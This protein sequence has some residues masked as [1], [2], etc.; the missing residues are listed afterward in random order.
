MSGRADWAEA[1]RRQLIVALH[2]VRAHIERL[3]AEQADRPES[4]PVRAAPSGRRDDRSAGPQ[5]SALDALVH[6]FGLT[7][8]E[9]DVLVLAAGTELDAGFA[10]LLAKATGQTPGQ[11]T[12]S[13]ALAALPDAHWSAITPA[14]PLRRWRLIDVAPGHA[15]VA[16]PLRIDER[17]LHFLVGTPHP[18]ERLR[19]IVAHSAPAAPAPIARPA[20]VE[21]LVAAW[22]GRSAGRSP[23]IALHGGDAELRRAMAA[24]VAAGLGLGMLTVRIDRVP[25]APDERVDLL[26]L[27]ERECAL[28]DAV[29]LLDEAETPERGHDRG[30]LDALDVLDVPVI[31]SATHPPAGTDRAIINAEVEPLSHIELRGLWQA[32][33]GEGVT[34][35]NGALDRVAGCFRLGPAGVSAVGAAL[36]ATPDAPVTE[37]RL[38]GLC[39]TWARPRLDGLA[40]RISPAATWR[41][42]VLPPAQLDMLRSIALHV[43]HRLTVHEDWGFADRSGRGTGIAALFAGP[44]GTGKTMAAEVLANELDFDLYRIDLSQVVSKYIGETEKN[45]RRVFD[46]AE[47]GSAILLFD[48]ADALFG[49]R[50]EVKDSHDRYANI[51][52]SYLLQ[53][54]EVYRGL[55][56][57]TTNLAAAI[58]PAFLRRLRFSVTFP[59][60]DAASRTEIWRRVFP[61]RAPTDGLDPTRLARL[62]IPGGNIRNIALHA[63]FF[64]ADAVE[65]VRM[66]HVLRAARLEYAKLERTLTESEMAAW[67]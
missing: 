52:V 62:S 10:T 5:E 65:P 41:D 29:L 34:Q 56:I 35:W 61:D 13:L 15:L 59:F 33:L 55:A 28:S 16:S 67:A 47:G 17:V 58:D 38:W 31:V 39:R 22:S 4:A 9:R 66:Q 19:G 30:L 2:A 49:K 12:F 50:S 11:A 8:F 63:A 64:A 51:E 18:E 3:L 42:L 25:A 23:V 36:R 21:R 44:S 40:R 20:Q 45:L 27:L 57:L 14:A 1:N 37:D 7:S 48:E 26:R 24:A 54:M 32:A 6:R 60:P 46:A 53:R 43:R